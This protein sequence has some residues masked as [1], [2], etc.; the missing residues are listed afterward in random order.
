[1]FETYLLKIFN[2][3]NAPNNRYYKVMPIKMIYDVDTKKECM[4][5]SGPWREVMQHWP[6]LGKNTKTTLY[7]YPDHNTH[8]AKLVRNRPPMVSNIRFELEY[9]HRDC[10]F[11]LVSRNPFREL[12]HTSEF[13]HFK[14]DVSYPKM[15]TT[16]FA[17]YKERVVWDTERFLRYAGPKLD[18]H[19][20]KDIRMEDLFEDADMV[21]DRWEV[22]TLT[23]LEPLI[24]HRTTDLNRQTLEQGRT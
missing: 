5:P 12:E 23:G 11:N 20:C 13:D 19:D 7:T 10:P 17:H 22:H 2:W 4:F 24:I 3:W 14:E 18:F 16:V 21:P 1:M 9:V 8:I 6:E 15:I